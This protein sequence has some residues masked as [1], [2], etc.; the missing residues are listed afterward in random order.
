MHELDYLVTLFYTRVRGT[1]IV[2]T[3]EL[4]SDVLRIPKVERPDY[5]SCEQLRTVSKDEMISTFFS[6]PL[7]GVI[8]SLHH[9][10]PLLK[11]L[12]S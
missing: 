1:H 2:V 4:V 12:D 11:F 3:P 9:V 5:L 10:R 7:I 6:I 8:V